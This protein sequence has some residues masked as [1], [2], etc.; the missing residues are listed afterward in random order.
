MLVAQVQSLLKQR[1]TFS[2]EDFQT[3]FSLGVSN[4]TLRAFACDCAESVLHIFEKAYPEDNRPKEAIKMAH[5]FINN[6]IT[7][8]ELVRAR[9][10]AIDAEKI[11]IYN[12]QLEQAAIW[13]AT[14]AKWATTASAQEAARF[15]AMS[16]LTAVSQASQRN[17]SALT[18]QRQ[19]QKRY[20]VRRVDEQIKEQIKNVDRRSAIVATRAKRAKV[21]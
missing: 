16:A 11:K 9:N 2:R 18:Y 19:L 6:I 15:A 3:L 17:K 1:D 4:Q 14:A 10:A 13:A 21:S 20:L 7:E 8:E 5:L 12:S